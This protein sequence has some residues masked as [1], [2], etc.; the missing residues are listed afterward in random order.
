MKRQT[1]SHCKRSLALDKFAPSK[2]RLKGKWCRACK[3]ENYRQRIKRIKWQ[4]RRGT[5]L[6]LVAP[7]GTATQRRALAKFQVELLRIA[8][9]YSLY[10]GA[11]T[12]RNQHGHTVTE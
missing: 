7:N 3:A 2:R 8:G 12:W 4:G 1:C 5:V 9:G 6:S 11:G 10:R